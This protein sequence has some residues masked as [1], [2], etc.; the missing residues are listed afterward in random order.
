MK[1]TKLL[2]LLLALALLLTLLPVS[3]LAAD[4]EAAAARDGDY[5]VDA[6]TEIAG[7][8]ARVYD[9][10]ET[11]PVS[12]YLPVSIKGDRAKVETAD[13]ALLAD[14]QGRTDFVLDF[15][16]A[17]DL[18]SAEISAAAVRVKPLPSRQIIR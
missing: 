16:A 15:T 4:D 5:V 11:D 18:A 17:G 12:L 2:P 10:S 6:D 13:P 7:T 9:G 14:L 3:A 1:R 8:V